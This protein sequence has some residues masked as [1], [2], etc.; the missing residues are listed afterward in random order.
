MVGY[1]LIIKHGISIFTIVTN[2][3]LDWVYFVWIYCGIIDKIVCNVEKDEF[4]AYV[5]HV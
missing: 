2:I 5:C 3:G 4:N 1:F